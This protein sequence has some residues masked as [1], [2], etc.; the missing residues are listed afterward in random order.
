M[1]WIK[2]MILVIYFQK[3]NMINGTKKMEKKVN[4]SQKNLLLK[5]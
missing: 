3:M 1:R 2:N 4:D 5:E